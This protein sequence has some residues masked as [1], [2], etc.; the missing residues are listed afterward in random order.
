MLQDEITFRKSRRLLY[1]TPL[2]QPSPMKEFHESPAT[3][4]AIFGGNRSGKTTAGGLEFLMHVTGIYPKWYPEEQ[5]VKGAIKG[6]ISAEDF[7]KGV[8]EVIIPFL[9]EWLDMNLIAKK[10]RNPMGVPVKWVLKN[11]SVFDILTYE[12]KTEVFEGWK[13]HIAWF[14][15]PPPRDKYV[16]TMRGLVDFHGRN[17]LTLTPLTEPWIYDELY[18][19]QDKNVAVFTTDIRDNTTLSEAAIKDFE[20]KLSEEE[21]EA[22]LHGRFLHLSGLIYK[23]F[24][25]NVHIC[26]RPRIKESWTRYFA[27]DPH[28]RTPTACL[29]LAVDPHENH[30]IY[31][32]LWLDGMDLEHMAHA[33]HAQEGN[34][35]P[36][37]R[38]I[39]PHMDKENELVG[40]FNV[41][42]ELMKHGI[43]C[44]R[45]NSDP[46]LGKS[47]IKHA[48]KPQYSA[49]YKTEVPRLRVARNCTHT[50]YEFEH[51]IWDEYRHRKDEFDPKATPKKKNDH[52][53][54]CLRYIYNYDPR[55]FPP[56]TDEPEPVWEGEYVK[57][58]SARSVDTAGRH[59]YDELVERGGQF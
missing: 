48:L 36:R 19:K 34:I 55:Y 15:E 56:D 28:E 23:E 10:I 42:K 7:T 9:E 41:R 37:I 39:D 59:N 2:P 31:D 22:R 5:R 8:G 30:Y 57:Y 27:I 43:Y 26:E 11:G 32:E 4:R 47:R 20:S 40:G 21:K 12:Q 54:D 16:A 58:P 33:I 52:F 24:N 38:L 25:P 29:W 50:I 18:T 35:V 17:W 51:Y 1:Y 14:D 46:L 53:M 49:V 45:G 3:T 6:R 13:G 44:E